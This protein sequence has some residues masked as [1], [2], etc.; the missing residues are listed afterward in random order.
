MTGNVTICGEISPL[1]KHFTRLWL[2]FEDLFSIVQ[3]FEP[4]SAN[5]VDIGQIFIAVNDQKL[6]KQYSHLVT[7]ATGLGDVSQADMGEINRGGLPDLDLDFSKSRGGLPDLDL[8]PTRLNFC[9]DIIPLE[10]SCPYNY[11]Q[12]QSGRP[13]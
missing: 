9:R 6:N 8:D 5:F 10:I 12:D 13:P 2:L 11:G 3:N 7:L 1:W 4:T